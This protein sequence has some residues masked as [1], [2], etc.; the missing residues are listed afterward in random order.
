MQHNYNAILLLIK[1]ALTGKKVEVPKDIDWEVIFKLCRKHQINPIIYYGIMNSGIQIDSEITQKFFNVV[2]QGVMV[3]KNQFFAFEKI[4]NEFEKNKIDYLPLK[5][6]IIKNLYPKSEMRMMGDMDILIRPESIEQVCELL[7]KN[8]FVKGDVTENVVT[9]NFPPIV[10]F[11]MHTALVPTEDTDYFD[12]FKNHWDKAKL[13]KEDSCRYEFTNE[14]VFIFVFV[15]LVKHYRE[16]GIGIRQFL[17]IWL[18]LKKLNDLDMQYIEKE[19]K[20]LSLTKFYNNI[21]ATLEVWFENKTPTDITDFITLRTFESGSYG[22]L[23]K[24]HAARAER[25]IQTKGVK[26][27]STFRKV[28]LTLFPSL[29]VM[30]SLYPV[31]KKVPVLLPIMWVARGFNTLLFKRKNVKHQMERIKNSTTSAA[32]EYSNELEYVGLKFDL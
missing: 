31:L 15:H 4:S 5:G 22:T 25:L 23:E 11:E 9:Y 8:K 30:K 2:M 20:K 27:N 17:D 13:I 29:T 19:L 14:D 24:H 1:S 26:K 21:I 7:E 3:E 6:T 32:Q 16:G 12:Y 18:M 10:S 28:I